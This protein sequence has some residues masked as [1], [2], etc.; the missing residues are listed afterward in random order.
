MNYL[1]LLNAIACV[2]AEIAQNGFGPTVTD[3]LLLN[4]GSGDFVALNDGSGVVLLNS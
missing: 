1:A 4:D 2:T 3:G